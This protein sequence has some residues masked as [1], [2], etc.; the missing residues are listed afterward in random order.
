[1]G[2]RA[3]RR[4]R[5]DGAIRSARSMGHLAEERMERPECIENQ[6]IIGRDSPDCGASVHY[7]ASRILKKRQLGNCASTGKVSAVIG[8]PA[9][10]R[11]IKR[12]PF[13]DKEIRMRTRYLMAP[14]LL[15]GACNKGGQVAQRIPADSSQYFRSQVTELTT[16]AAAKDSLVR[17]L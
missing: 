15:L 6:R 10:A 17:D 8:L 11:A 13:H 5:N 9:L 14:L 3:A 1:T 4:R 7:C 2:R 12:K 16:V